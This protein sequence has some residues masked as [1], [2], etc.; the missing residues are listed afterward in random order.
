MNHLHGGGLKGA[1]EPDTEEEEGTEHQYL[2]LRV[3]VGVEL[4]AS[5]GPKF[6]LAGSSPLEPCKLLPAA[7]VQG[8]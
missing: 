2:W 7:L 6:L 3:P 5:G 8:R 1:T 4:A